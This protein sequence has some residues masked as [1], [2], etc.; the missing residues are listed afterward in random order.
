M[1]T[2][3]LDI[4]NILETIAP[5]NLAESWDNVGL[6]I[7]CRTNEVTGI[8]IGLDPQPELITQAVTIGA[9][10]IITHHP[11]IFHP[12]H[13]IHT[14]N[15]EGRVIAESL[16]NDISII[17]CHT[18]LDSTADGVNDILAQGLQLQDS[19]PLTLHKNSCDSKL[20]GLGRIGTY[21]HPI[22]AD[23]FIQKLKNFCNP[24]WLLSA[25]PRPEKISKVAVCGGSCSDLATTA[26]TKEADVF[27]TAEVKHSIARWAE[28]SGLWIIDA[29]HF[30]TENVAM[31]AFAEKLQSILKQNGD[32]T[33]VMTA[34]QKS[35]LQLI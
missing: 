35:P 27:V 34:S 16:A 14:D 5:E 4:V 6:T 29:G 18:N 11:I 31:P 1:P 7:G 24:S 9:N 15:P 33:P 22:T 8:L 21:Q 20:C 28:A 17:S 10:L 26:K 2:T 25:G 12:L 23:T 19:K 13:S 3:V 32:T 30:A